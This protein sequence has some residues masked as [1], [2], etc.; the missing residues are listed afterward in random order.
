MLLDVK[1]TSSGNIALLETLYKDNEDDE[2]VLEALCKILVRMAAVGE[3][4]LHYYRKAIDN[5]LKITQLFEYY[6]MSRRQD[7]MSVMP[8]LLL[9][10]FGYNNNLDY[11]Y[12]AYL[13]PISYITS[14]TIYRCTAAICRRCSCLPVS[15]LR[16]DM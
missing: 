11:R 12:K 7:D 9:M 2:V 1:S 13:L 3:K 10:Y 6:I 15:R 16:W 14:R 4:Y 8:K 5:E